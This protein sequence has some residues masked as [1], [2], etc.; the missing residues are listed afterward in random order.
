M[1]RTGPRPASVA[2]VWE[3]GCNWQSHWDHRIRIG[4]EEFPRNFLFLER[5]NRAYSGE[6]NPKAQTQTCLALNK[7]KHVKAFCKLQSIV[8]M[9][10][11]ILT[12]VE[13]KVPLFTRVH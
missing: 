5:K 2:E 3:A 10:I 8:Q 7:K 9:L 6:I 13:Q 1:A 11:A 12:Q 4:A